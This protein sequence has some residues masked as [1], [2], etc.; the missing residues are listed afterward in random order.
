VTKKPGADVVTDSEFEVKKRR[1]SAT[2][3]VDDS[4]GIVTG[5]FALQ[6]RDEALSGIRQYLRAD[7]ARERG[8]V[9]FGR[10]AAGLNSGTMFLFVDDFLPLESEDSSLYHFSF[11][12]KSFLRLYDCLPSFLPLYPVGWFHSH[13]GFGEPFMSDAD[14]LLHQSHFDEPWHL[15]LVVDVGLWSM[16]VGFWRMESEELITVPEFCVQMTAARTLREQSGRFLRA[17]LPTKGPLHALLDRLRAILP[18]IPGFRKREL[19]RFLRGLCKEERRALRSSAAVSPLREL[20]QFASS[21]SSDQ[22]VEADAVLVLE[23][24]SRVRFVEDSFHLL[25]QSKWLQSRLVIYGDLCLSFEPDDG[26]LIYLA[27]LVRNEIRYS[28]FEPP[29]QLVD[30]CCSST[31]QL[32]VVTDDKTL[33]T[34]KVQEVDK[35]ERLL[36]LN[37]VELGEIEGEVR[38]IAISEDCLVVRSSSVMIILRIHGMRGKHEEIRLE[39][40]SR[41]EIPDLGEVAVLRGS[42]GG[43]FVTRGEG[44]VSLWNLE[45]EIIAHNDRMTDWVKLSFLSQAVWCSVGLALLFQN[46]EEFKIMICDPHTLELKSCYVCWQKN[47]LSTE[48]AFVADSR[49]RMFVK[50]DKSLYL[51]DETGKPNPDWYFAKSS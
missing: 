51:V 13:L 25:L 44:G 23:H 40:E 35:N 38:E 29:Q 34:L 26:G 17:C 48:V 19:Y 46:K 15:S 31:G 28:Q 10:R 5:T 39:V 41:L 36:S 27:N 32:W 37:R 14:C 12:D 2:F 21:V 20:F 11:T 18:D 42:P 22:S 6:I 30:V 4:T 3:S 1:T 9:L 24:L 45:G 8:G 16:P 49:G 47:Q 50:A 33:L 43:G 7:Q